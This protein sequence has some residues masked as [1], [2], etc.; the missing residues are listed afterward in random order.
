MPLEFLLS[1]RPILQHLPVE[2]SGKFDYNRNYAKNAR[3]EG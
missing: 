2:I 3:K 1:L